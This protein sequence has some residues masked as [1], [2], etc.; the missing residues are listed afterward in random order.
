M[1]TEGIFEVPGAELAYTQQ[2]N[3]PLLFLVGAP[4]GRSGFAALAER[5]ATNFT[6]IT[7]DPRG[8]GAS[9]GGDNGPVTPA[10]LATDLLALIQQQQPEEPVLLFGASGGA[11]TGIELLTQH[12]EI[13]GLLVVHEPPLFTLL[14]DADAVMPHAEAAFQ[15][16]PSNPQAAVQAFADLTEALH[17]TTVLLPRPPRVILPALPAAELEKNRFFL[18]Q[19]A[20]E[21]V[22]YR[23][24]IDRI[25]TTKLRLAAGESSVGQPA[26]QATVQL[27]E[28]L[29]LPLLNAPGNHLGIGETERF[30]NW[31]IA[32]LAGS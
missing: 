6:V 27:A 16:A 10:L 1:V 32:V 24:Q 20:P 9:T 25:P 7:H 29:N 22:R 17:H 15:L 4:V 2:G 14:P 26:R 12:P 13:V 23:P 19:M 18:G 5:L 8:I 21:T 28:A 31:L 11:V 3:G 30:A